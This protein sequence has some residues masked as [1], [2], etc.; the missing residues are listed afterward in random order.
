MTKLSCDLASLDV[1]NQ[2]GTHKAFFLWR[3]DE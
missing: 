3:D 1:V 2:M